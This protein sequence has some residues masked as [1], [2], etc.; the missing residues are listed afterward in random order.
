MDLNFD[1]LVKSGNSLKFVIPAKAGVQSF[2]V[3]LNPGAC[4][5]HDPGFAA[6]DNQRGSLR[7]HQFLVS[8]RR[9]F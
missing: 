6:G 2:Q 1:E 4:P 7:D 5:G 9:G 3:I 8:L